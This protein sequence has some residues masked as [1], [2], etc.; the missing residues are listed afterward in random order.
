MSLHEGQPALQFELK[1]IQGGSLSL[2]EALAQGPVVAAFFKV[3][4]PTCQYTFPF[5]ERLHRIFQD[6][7]AQVWGIS[8]DNR[9]DTEEFC[10]EYNITFPVLLD[11]T[12]YTISNDYGLYFVPTLYMID[13]DGKVQVASEGFCRADLLAVHNS[14]MNSSDGAPDLFGKN[15]SIPEYKPG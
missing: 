13:P 11:E 9:E 8:Q 12:N 14:I 5:L 7:P 4:C 10:R 15:E 3:S 2:K 6:K 1:S